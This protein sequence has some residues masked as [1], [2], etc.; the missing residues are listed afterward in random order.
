MAR[1]VR[2]TALATRSAAEGFDASPSVVARQLLLVVGA[3]A[4]A[5]ARDPGVSAPVIRYLTQDEIRRLLKTCEAP[6]AISCTPR[7]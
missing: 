7:S 6:S 1:T 4:V 5:P 2:D 3:V